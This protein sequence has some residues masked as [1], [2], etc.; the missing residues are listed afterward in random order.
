MAQSVLPPE[1]SVVAPDSGKRTRSK[2]L[3]LVKII[4]AAGFV[5][6][7]AECLR[8]FV[9][10]NFHTVVPGRCY[11]AAQPTAAFLESIKHSHGIASIVNLRDENPDE[12][13]YREEQK[14]AKQL[15]IELLNAGLSSKEQPPDVDFHK[16]VW[17]MKNAKEP[18]LI[19]CANG[20]DRSG[21]ASAVFLLMRTD[22][23]LAQARGQL[24][25]RYG[26]FSWTKSSCLR[27]ILDSYES[28]LDETGKAHSP[29]HFYYWGLNVYR[30]ET[31]P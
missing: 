23:P 25:I 14:A 15:N 3:L 19:H 26:H 10:A 17:A 18:V 31:L 13:W 30:Q 5:M 1:P 29:D 9:G 7:S 8:I 28:W 21:L 27:R 2:P 6:F 24:S 12:A 11:R 22:T 16:F 4:A 20:N